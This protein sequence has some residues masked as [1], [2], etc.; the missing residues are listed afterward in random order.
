VRQA[1]HEQLE[2][3]G[4]AAAPALRQALMKN[5]SPEVRWRARDILAKLT[6]D[7]SR[8]ERV[9]AARVVEALEKMDTAEARR[10]LAGLA[11]GARDSYLTQEAQAALRR[12]DQ[13]AAGP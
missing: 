2:R 4:G 13:R 6:K 8:Q 5:R 7:R 12:L 10:S 3:W 1:A 9:N 11:G